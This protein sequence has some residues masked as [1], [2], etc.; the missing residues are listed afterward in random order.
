[1]PRSPRLG[2]R[3]GVYLVATFWQF[4]STPG[5]ALSGVKDGG[6]AYPGSHQAITAFSIPPVSGIRPAAHGDG[7]HSAAVVPPQ[8]AF[9]SGHPGDSESR[10]S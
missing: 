2:D 1:M 5:V 10:G 7:P 8:A 3:E 6:G 4:I 9:G